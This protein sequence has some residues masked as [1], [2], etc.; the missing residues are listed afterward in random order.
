MTD[1]IGHDATSVP[2]W[3]PEL[4][5][6]VRADVYPVSPPLPAP[7]PAELVLD[8]DSVTSGYAEHRPPYEF[9]SL[10]GTDTVSPAALARVRVALHALSKAPPPVQQRQPLLGP[11]PTS[12]A[13]SISSRKPFPLQKPSAKSSLEDWFNR[14]ASGGAFSTAALSKAVPLGPAI[15]RAVGK[16]LEMMA[17]R[18]VPTQ[19][20]VWYIRI[21]V[22]NECVKQVRPD[23][24]A[25]SPRVFWTRQLCGLLKTELE[26]F[27]AKR[28]PPAREYFWQYVL[29]LA[30]WQADESLLDLP[31]WLDRVAAAVRM[32][33]AQGGVIT[34]SAGS[35]VVLRAAETFINN[36]C[37]SPNAIRRLTDALVAAVEAAGGAA[38]IS[39]P[40]ATAAA[41][42]AT[43]ATVTAS[44]TAA[45]TASAGGAGG[46]SN[47]TVP[48]IAPS[49]ISCAKLPPAVRVAALLRTLLRAAGVASERIPKC[50]D[51]DE[52]VGLVELAEREK[53]RMAAPAADPLAAA[54]LAATEEEGVVSSTSAQSLSI[55]LERTPCCGDIAGICTL[56]RT[57]F[58]SNGR[59]GS[60]AIVAFLCAWA[61]RGPMRMSAHAVAIASSCI[62]ELDAGPR[63]GGSAQDGLPAFQAEIWFY[64]KTLDAVRTAGVSASGG[65]QGSQ[66]EAVR[67][68]SYGYFVDPDETA[69]NA[70]M[71]RL[72]A[73]LY[74]VGQFSLSSYL[75][76]VGRLV[77]SSHP[78]ARRHLLYISALP[79]PS[80]RSSADSRR[81]LLRRGQRIAGKLPGRVE[82]DDQAISAVLS[83]DVGAAVL[84]G[85]RI[86]ASGS[87]AVSLA[88]AEAVLGPT[89]DQTDAPEHRVFSVLAFLSSSGMQL[90]AVEWL[91]RILGDGN[92]N[93]LVGDTSAVC[94][95]VYALDNLAPFVASSGSLQR[96]IDLISSLS[97]RYQKVGDGGG[98]ASVIL[99]L[100]STS[101]S[102]SA[103]FAPNSGSGNASWPLWVAKVAEELSDV[104][105]RVIA[106]FLLGSPEAVSDVSDSTLA[107]LRRSVEGPQY[108]A[109]DDDANCSVEHCWGLTPDDDLARMETIPSTSVSL[110]NLASFVSFRGEADEEAAPPVLGAWVTANAVMGCVVVPEIKRAFLACRNGGAEDD[111]NHLVNV[112]NSSLELLR[113]GILEHDLYGTRTTLAVEL[114][115]LLGAA[116]LGKTGEKADRLL[117]EVLRSPWAGI[118]LL[119][120]AGDGLA[121]RLRERLESLSG[122]GADAVAVSR[123]VLQCAVALFG[124]PLL[125]EDS[126]VVDEGVVIRLFAWVEWG[127][128]E[129]L[130]SAM[131]SSRNSNGE[132]EEFGRSIGEAAGRIRFCEQA[133]MLMEIIVRCSPKGK[134]EII[135]EQL[136]TATV[137]GLAQGMGALVEHVLVE[138]SRDQTVPQAEREAWAAFDATRCTMM[139]TFS[140]LLEPP[141]E[142]VILAIVE[143]LASASDKL[144]SPDAGVLRPDLSSNGMMFS[145]AVESRFL[146]LEKLL[147]KCGQQSTAAPNTAGAEKGEEEPL[148]TTHEKTMEAAVGIA[149]IMASATPLLLPS[150]LSAGLKALAVAVSLAER[151]RPAMV[152]MPPPAVVTSLAESSSNEGI[153]EVA[154]A[155]ES[156]L[157]EVKVSL[158][159]RIGM[160]LS[161]IEVWLD[162]SQ[163][164]S[165][166]S[167]CSRRPDGLLAATGNQMRICALNVDG[168]EIDTW[169]LLEGYGR[170]AE[171]EAAISVQAFDV[172]GGKSKFGGGGRK[173]KGGLPPVLVDEDG[174]AEVAVVRLKRTYSTYCELTV[175]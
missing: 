22:L 2:K 156:D 76:E 143:Q 98:G 52:L 26:A 121:R 140:P 34:A 166:R 93:Q 9:G 69:E 117:R 125:S 91:L 107:A 55:L 8:R 160:L 79:E 50:G 44:A 104:S 115:A 100:E 74:H 148:A 167:I 108:G 35:R 110:Q 144:Q 6:G 49:A 128:T 114:L 23:R 57:T 46:E 99:A 61:V 28:L 106:A 30:R 130:L 7:K 89:H 27:R 146:V 13:A 159:S 135:V 72:I 42:E 62:V 65:S 54:S 162:A 126:S 157:A 161:P 164:V 137:E 60:R 85:I 150:A 78:S 3:V 12:S 102:F 169:N 94:A 36:F 97:V 152:S 37:A 155:A 139:T 116:S 58:D 64:V 17:A 33:L 51:E 129:F 18:S 88:T 138:A 136:A 119:P 111:M 82:A 112:L 71:V 153:P 66:E 131:A 105:R 45:S 92:R 133:E 40:E 47:S 25:P 21:A 77:A 70:R 123:V 73:H 39:S 32:D 158:R 68:D 16:V 120:M 19:R 11:P 95:M 170:G 84:N 87:L 10:L 141:L 171:E 80:D 142:S 5:L 14:L 122:D 109:D 118:V 59:G 154:A 56:L 173:G 29:D 53:A 132:I 1:D 149:N 43:S 101:A 24:P 41:E 63:D 172:Q 175:R 15:V 147:L 151:V 48:A 124:N 31:P 90:M 163:Q 113:E 165:L 145:S 75:K 134:I 174:V 127:V 81:A 38:V 168:S 67:K 83:N 103:R 20:A 4:R 96:C 86:Q